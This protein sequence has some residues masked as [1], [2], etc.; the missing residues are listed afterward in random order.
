MIGININV[1]DRKK[2]EQEVE[3]LSQRIV[4]ATKGIGIGTWEWDIQ[5]NLLD[6]DEQVFH[7]FG[8]ARP[9]FGGEYED[10]RST[11]HPDDIERVEKEL[12]DSIANKKNNNIE[13]FWLGIV[14]LPGNE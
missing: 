8:L 10:W 3:R 2:T 4:A 5:N 9:D 13:N 11:V 6:S 1:T 12:V 14:K 7:L